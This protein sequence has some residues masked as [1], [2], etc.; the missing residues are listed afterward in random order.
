MENGIRIIQPYFRTYSLRNFNKEG[1]K[2][3]CSFY[4]L[5]PRHDMEEDIKNRRI[6]IN[7][8][9]PTCDTP[10]NKGD[11]ISHTSHDHEPPVRIDGIRKIL[12]DDQILAVS[13]PPY[14]PVHPCGRYYY[15]SLVRIVEDMFDLKELK[16]Q[17]RLDKNVSG[18]TVFLKTKSMSQIFQNL[19]INDQV[20][21]LYL[22]RV[23]GSF[24]EFIECNERIDMKEVLSFW[25]DEGKDAKTMFYKICS[26]GSK[27]LVMCKL[28]TGRQ[29][30]IRA[31][32]K[33][34][35]HPICDDEIYNNPEIFPGNIFMKNP[36]DEFKKKVLKKNTQMIDKD[37]NLIPLQTAIAE[38]ADGCKKCKKSFYINKILPTIKLHCVYTGF[39]KYKIYD[40]PSWITEAERILVKNTIEICLA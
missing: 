30:Q 28:F 32:L 5:Y 16:N 40:Y 38:K 19:I 4:K 31:H 23:E 20:S 33:T 36:D 39:L 29:H 6:F 11:S 35:N 1:I 21:K 2:D 22:A 14:M 12:E 8:Q 18:L 13:K 9:L 24:P 37:D 17:S 27:S 10:L 15:N 3:L 26:D 34:L 25:S 7:N